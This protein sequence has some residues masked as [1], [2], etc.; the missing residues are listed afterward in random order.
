ML[1]F[2][3]KTSDKSGGVL[4]PAWHPN[5]RNFERLP[6]AKAVRQLMIINILAIFVVCI[7]ALYAGW[8]ERQLGALRSETNEALRVIEA[9]KGPS[10]NAVALYKKFVEEEKKIFALNDFLSESP[11]IVSDFLLELGASVP[12][13]VDIE[14][15][16]YKSTAVVLRGGIDG[17]SEEATERA[18]A[19][20]KDLQANAVFAKLFETISLPSIGRDPGTGR[21]RFEINLKFG[22]AAS[23]Q[24][25]KGGKK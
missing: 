15:I 25:S 6:D 21:I 7:L 1:S 8:R 3:K 24:K 10:E 11:M 13:L 4:V 14:S 12:Q 17:P 20:V 16:D 5:F 19:Y 18:I 22:G 23:S 2:L 9:T